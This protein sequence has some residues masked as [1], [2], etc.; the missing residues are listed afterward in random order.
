MYDLWSELRKIYIP[1]AFKFIGWIPK[2]FKFE[3]YMYMKFKEGGCSGRDR[4]TILISIRICNILTG[5]K[6]NSFFP[7]HILSWRIFFLNTNMISRSP[8]ITF[9]RTIKHPWAFLTFVFGIFPLICA[10]FIAIMV[11]Y[12]L[13]ISAIF[14]S[15]MFIFKSPL[16]IYVTAFPLHHVACSIDKSLEPGDTLLLIFTGYWY[17]ILFIYTI[18]DVVQ[19]LFSS[20]GVR[21][22]S[23]PSSTK[24]TVEAIL[25]ISLEIILARIHFV[26]YYLVVKKPLPLT[27]KA[28]LLFAVLVYIVGNVIVIF[29]AETSLAV[30]NVVFALMCI[31]WVVVIDTGLE[32]AGEKIVRDFSVASFLALFLISGPVLFGTSYKAITSLVK[33]GTGIVKLGPVLLWS[34][35]MGLTNLVFFLL[36]KRCLEPRYQ[37]IPLYLAQLLTDL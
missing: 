28:R 27:S 35:V 7:H 11:H 10:I 30:L 25:F 8:S 23:F 31:I 2:L 1:K 26:Y 36:A 18:S 6:L 37:P 9:L 20:L 19:D 22:L 33:D 14:Y 21:P 3:G 15:V 16:T 12:W 29:Y 24:C 32:I 13:G 34:F 4:N 17:I 5:V